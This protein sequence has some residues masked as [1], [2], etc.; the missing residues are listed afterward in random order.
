M[1]LLGDGVA[2]SVSRIATEL[3]LEVRS[4]FWATYDL[5][6]LGLLLRSADPVGALSL[7]FVDGH[8]KRLREFAYVAASGE[9]EGVVVDG[10]RHVRSQFSKSPNCAR[11]SSSP[12]GTT[13]SQVMRLLDD[14][15]PRSL[16]Q[17]AQELSVSESSVYHAVYVL[18]G[19]G[20][21]LRTEKPQV[22][23]NV[24]K[25]ERPPA[26]HLWTIS[27]EGEKETVINGVKYVRYSKR[28]GKSL[29]QHIIEYVREHLRDKAAFT[30]QVRKDLEERLGVEVLQSMVMC[31]LSKCRHGEVYL[32][33]Y[34]GAERMT[35]FE[36]GFAV[37]WLDPIL[38]REQSLAEAK[39]RTDKFLQGEQTT[40]PLFQRVHSIFDIVTDVSL[41]RD[42]ASQIFVMSELG[43]SRHQ[44]ELA[45]K[46]TLELYPRIKR[47]SIFVDERG[48]YG[49]SHYY[50]EKVLNQEDLQAAVKAKEQYLMKVKSSDERKG[51][52][53]EG[54]VWWSLERFR[55]ARFLPQKHRTEGMHPYRH[56]LHLI[57]PVRRRKKSAEID[58]VWESREPALLCNNEEVTN[59]IEVK[60][61][62]IRRDDVEDFLDIARFSKEFGAGDRHGR[63][64]RNGVVLWMAGAAIDNKASILVGNDY[65]TVASFASRLGIK[66]IPVSQINE[67]LQRRGW[68]KASVKAICRVAKDAYEAMEILDQIWAHPKEAEEIVTKCREQ[69]KSILEQERMLEARVK[70]L[71]QSKTVL[72]VDE[73]ESEAAEEHANS[74]KPAASG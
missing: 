31:V 45:L 13:I 70:K 67:Q 29:S 48:E 72:D 65:L 19:R 73:N 54:V 27:P 30:T 74:E 62:L 23:E 58:G 59:L 3:P 53:L 33:G 55:R 38:P 26:R 20:G 60:F 7:E 34:Q 50:N 35:P 61:N 2:R 36:Q 14:G 40:S 12:R 11:S 43:C 68:E 9:V 46:K 57:K 16:R 56:T 64:I 24:R 47:V 6:R 25:W 8:S 42:I 10:V 18:Y 44:L 63:V 21:I 41:K 37:T 15:Q 69:N 71:R 4:V 51:H 52:A 5:Y 17:I 66:F 49:Y 22:Q 28:D 39:E 32:R 1:V